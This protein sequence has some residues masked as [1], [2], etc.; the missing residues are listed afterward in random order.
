MNWLLSFVS[1]MSHAPSFELVFLTSSLSNWG[2][3]EWFIENLFLRLLG[4]RLWSISHRRG[5][6]LV[7]NVA[8]L[9]SSTV[10]DAKGS[11]GD[12][13]QFLI[14]VLK[15]TA[16]ILVGFVLEHELLVQAVVWRVCT[17]EFLLFGLVAREVIVVLPKWRTRASEW[18]I[19]FWNKLLLP[20]NNVLFRV[21]LVPNVLAV[22][23]R[24]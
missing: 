19:H 17:A 18:D 2:V 14:L 24:L 13:V 16:L 7:K 8:V 10:V 3:Q 1:Y 5:I 11:V 9:V 22:L 23:E 4:R 6:S 21:K 12:L 15:W 20:R